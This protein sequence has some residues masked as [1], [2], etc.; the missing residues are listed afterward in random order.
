MYR[1]NQV[2]N[3]EYG[4]YTSASF[5]PDTVRVS[6]IKIDITK[7]DIIINKYGF[8]DLYQ[9]IKRIKRLTIEQ[10]LIYKNYVMK[11]EDQRQ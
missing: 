5:M 10:Y 1:Q 8:I 3:E 9:G 2:W 6:N 11:V 7:C 4:C